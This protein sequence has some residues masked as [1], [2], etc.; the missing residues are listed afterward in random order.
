[1]IIAVCNQKGGVGKTTIATNLAHQL[2]KEGTVLLVDCDPQGNATTTIGIELER[3]ALTL[4][5]V[6]AAVAAG[7]DPTVVYQAIVT[8]PTQWGEV[9]ILPADRLLAS[10]QEDVGIGREYRLKTAL[11]P[12]VEDY[13]HIIIDCPPSLGVLTTNALVAADT[14]LIVTTA[15]EAAVD[16]VSEMISTIAACRSYYNQNLQLAGIL[17]NAHRPDRTDRQAWHETLQASFGSYLIDA[18]LPEREAVAH[19]ATAHT[20]IKTGLDPLIDTALTQ[21]MTIITS[22]ASA[23]S[24]A[25]TTSNVS[26]AGTRDLI[27]K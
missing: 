14:A 15:R 25:G 20:P 13:A 12:L 9:D 21:T 22:T 5:D 1:M 2:A 27:V 18:Y 10:R 11:R 16:G 8:A 7:Q 17:V 23:D 24:T 3:S 19:A 26:A 4:N 6:L